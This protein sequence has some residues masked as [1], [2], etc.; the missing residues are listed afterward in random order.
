MRG[1]RSLGVLRE[2]GQKT[3]CRCIFSPMSCIHKLIRRG[4]ILK[5]SVLKHLALTTLHYHSSHPVLCLSVPSQQ[6]SDTT[7][8]EAKRA[9][10]RY[11]PDRNDQEKNKIRKRR[12]RQP[13]NALGIKTIAFAR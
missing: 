10:F 4:R 12:R 2:W 1:L 13:Y 9:T 6:P 7:F 8:Y 5:F 11:D 3:S